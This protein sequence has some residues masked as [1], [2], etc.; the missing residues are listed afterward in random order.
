[1]KNNNSKKN[2]F[3][4][5]PIRFNE[6]TIK[7]ENDKPENVINE[8]E[9]PFI[10]EEI[11]FYLLRITPSIHRIRGHYFAYVS[12][13]IS[14]GPL[15]ANIEDITDT[16]ELLSY[17]NMENMYAIKIKKTNSNKFDYIKNDDTHIN[18]LFIFLDK[19][20]YTVSNIESV[21]SSLKQNEAPTVITIKYNGQILNKKDISN[22]DIIEN[23][24]RYFNSEYYYHF[25]D[26][27]IRLKKENNKKDEMIIYKN[28]IGEFVSFSC[29][30]GVIGEF[31]K[32]N[33]RENPRIDKFGVRE[34]IYV[35]NINVP[36][37]TFL[38]RSGYRILEDDPRLGIIDETMMEPQIIVKYK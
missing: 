25:E 14:N 35:I 37:K 31:V 3:N 22:I 32:I 8:Q 7:H 5:S 20:N 18:N 4:H 28:K 10:T 16:H 11:N 6:E 9:E 12:S 24:E 13:E 2:R 17:C 34:K 33:I 30:E 19:Y 27:E 26:D 1:M 23:K 36:L 15:Y 38:K 21:L 29:L